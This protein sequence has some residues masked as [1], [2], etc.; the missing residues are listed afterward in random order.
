[1]P[2][3]AARQLA[4]IIFSALLGLRS[5]ACSAARSST[6]LRHCLSS[7]ASPCSLFGIFSACQFR[8]NLARKNHVFFVDP[9]APLVYS[10]RR[11]IDAQEV[12]QFLSPLHYHHRIFCLGS[13]GLRRFLRRHHCRCHRAR[14][15]VNDQEFRGAS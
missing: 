5:E 13:I 6:Y 14:A 4:F 3:V 11:G 2:P 12:G 8:R 9:R 7:S 10:G 1:P 15:E